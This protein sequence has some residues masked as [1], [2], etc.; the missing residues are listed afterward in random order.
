MFLNGGLIDRSARKKEHKSHGWRI[1]R[2][3]QDLARLLD[4]TSRPYL[5][6][7]INSLS[8]C[9]LMLDTCNYHIED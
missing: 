9:L 2:A 7:A 6:S 8:T 4:P 3:S 1:W 5:P